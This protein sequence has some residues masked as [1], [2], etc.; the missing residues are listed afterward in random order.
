MDIYAL[1]RMTK[2]YN[3]NIIVIAGMAHI[4]KY[5]EFY[6]SNGWTSKWKGK[7]ISKKCVTVPILGVGKK[8]NV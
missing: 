8:Q 3:R 4:N 7:N 5:R 1:G 6:L 2:D